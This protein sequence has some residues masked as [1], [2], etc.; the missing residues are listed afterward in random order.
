M[1][2]NIY[3]EMHK[4]F[5]QL[6]LV[7]YYLWTFKATIVFYN[8]LWGLC[9]QWKKIDKFQSHDLIKHIIYDM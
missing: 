1:Y 7:A 9:F 2:D 4:T 3:N 6:E 5:L 8:K